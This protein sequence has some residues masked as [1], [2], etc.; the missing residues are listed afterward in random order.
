MITKPNMKGQIVIPK[1]IRDTLKIDQNSC[2]NITL[3]G[4][5]IYV[6]PVDEV[7]TKTETKSAFLAMLEKT[8]GSLA[9]ENWT[10]WEESEKR[11]RKGEIAAVKKNK[12][13]W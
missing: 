13:A 7:Y 4:S 8:K 2:L 1:E 11:Y 6:Q 5:G 12:K 9:E 10:A 3:A